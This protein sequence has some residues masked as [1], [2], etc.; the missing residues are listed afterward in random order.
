MKYPIKNASKKTKNFD[1]R[2]C[3]SYDV[4]DV[5]RRN[6]PQTSTKACNPLVN[7]NLITMLQIEA[8]CGVDETT[9]DKTGVDE[10]GCY[11]FLK[12][13]FYLERFHTRLVR[14]SRILVLTPLLNN[15]YF[16]NNGS[17]NQGVLQA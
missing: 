7:Q 9:V 8:K 11:H 17:N 15:F 2:N 6:P 1:F 12:G 4:V 14:L 5:P 10:L 13:A 16:A 3:S